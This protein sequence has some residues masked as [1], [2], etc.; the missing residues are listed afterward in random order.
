MIER[1][2]P[3]ALAALA[4]QTVKSPEFQR[5]LLEAARDSAQFV[6]F[7]EDAMRSGGNGEILE[8]DQKMDL[9]AA[10]F[11]EREFNDLPLDEDQQ[12]GTIQSMAALWPDLE[13][14][15][16]SEPGVWARVNLRMVEDGKV[17]PAYFAGGQNGGKGSKGLPRIDDALAK[18]GKDLDGCARRIVRSFAGCPQIRGIRT[19]YQD[20][21]PR[22]GLVD[23]PPRR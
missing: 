20:C 22:A 12:R 6:R 3:P 4:K 18:G 5:E 13:K 16:A 1:Y 10:P 23:A 9:P 2:I 8:G 7:V 11:C 17:K 15:D 19:L 14:R 21:P